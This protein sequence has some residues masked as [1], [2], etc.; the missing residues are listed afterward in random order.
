[1]VL[2]S[3]PAEKLN[4]CQARQAKSVNKHCWPSTHWRELDDGIKTWW[5][6]EKIARSVPIKM[7]K[8]RP[9]DY[10]TNVFAL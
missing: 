6:D 10:G 3:L 5:V 4:T 2:C 7:I 8:T 1:M 9:I